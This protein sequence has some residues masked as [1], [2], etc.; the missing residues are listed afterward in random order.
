VVPIE[1]IGWS[2]S[3][4]IAH[5]TWF[6]KYLSE[7][8]GLNLKASAAFA[9]LPFVAMAVA[10]SCG[11]LLSD[12]LVKRFGARTGRCGVAGVSPLAASVFVWSATK[13]DDARWAALI[14]AGGAGALYLAQSA[15]WAVSADLGGASAGRLSGIMNMGGQVG[16]V[17]TASMTPLIADAWGWTA[18]FAAAAAMCLLGALAWI[19]IDPQPRRG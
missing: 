2:Q 19:V 17:A 13:A 16:G 12:R 1:E 3:E 6:F 10:S 4:E 9:T 5:F 11:G 18:S 7:V 8:R 15:F 14:L